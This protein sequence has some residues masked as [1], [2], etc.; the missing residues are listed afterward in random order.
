[1]FLLGQ[2]AKQLGSRPAKRLNCV[3]RI[4]KCLFQGIRFGNQ[5]RVKRRSNNV[6][7]FLGRL[8]NKNQPTVAYGI[9]FCFFHK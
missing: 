7:A 4:Y 8:K 6:A 5:L 1:M 2:L 3:R 9:A